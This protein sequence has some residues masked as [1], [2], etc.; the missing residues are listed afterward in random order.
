[1]D[2]LTT[3]NFNEYTIEE[4]IEGWT[5]EEHVILALVIAELVLSFCNGENGLLKK[6]VEAIK[7]WLENPTSENSY[8][9]H[10]VACA[11]LRAAWDIDKAFHETSLSDAAFKAAYGD[12]YNDAWV[13]YYA[14]HA[15]HDVT[16]AMHA[17]DAA[18]CAAKI[19]DEIKQ[20]IIDYIN[21]K[22]E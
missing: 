3:E 14:A 15:V 18:R 13:A 21:S 2:K 8:A 19:N 20:K 17:A 5:N 4:F 10:R 22:G 11:A 16:P 6:S 9:A 12:D 1:M 7:K